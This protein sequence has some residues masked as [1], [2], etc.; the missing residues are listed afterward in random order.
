[1]QDLILCWL[2]I[3]WQ[4]SHLASSFW[5]SMQSVH[6]GEVV[7]WH[8][9]YKSS[10]KDFCLH[11]RSHTINHKFITWYWEENIWVSGA[12]PGQILNGFQKDTKI[13]ECL[14]KRAKIFVLLGGSGGMLSWKSLKIK[15]LRLAEIELSTTYFEDSFISHSVTNCSCNWRS[16][17]T[18]HYFVLN[19]HC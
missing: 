7:C 2:P 5:S 3:K 9:F 4:Y 8:Y 12:D 17:K 18:Y 6:S 19:F 15:C 10:F 14:E 16:F 13:S 11:D 1:M